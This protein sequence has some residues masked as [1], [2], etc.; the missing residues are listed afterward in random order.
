MT[1]FPV[2]PELK[3]EGFSNDD[4]SALLAAIAERGGPGRFAAWPHEGR[5]AMARVGVPDA[6]MADDPEG[7]CAEAGVV[8]VRFDAE[9]FAAFSRR[10]DPAIEPALIGRFAALVAPL[11]PDLHGG[12]VTGIRWRLE[13][14]DR[15]RRILDLAGRF[16]PKGRIVAVRLAPPAGL[17][18][19]AL[20]FDA[21]RHV[22]RVVGPAVWPRTVLDGGAL[23]GLK[24]LGGPVEIGLDVTA[25]GLQALLHER[26]NKQG[27][28][29]LF[30]AGDLHLEP[31]PLAARLALKAAR[32]V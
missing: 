28:A 8:G 7:V 32:I 15:T 4:L 29:A 13:P 5:W 20:V 24:T 10:F 14:A 16:L 9:G 30:G 3:V 17:R 22:T 11:L 23:A 25:A 21:Q 6:I 26:L 18:G 31:L 12:H 2:A 1:T 27:F 19:L